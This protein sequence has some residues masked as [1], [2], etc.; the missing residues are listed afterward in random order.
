MK[1]FMLSSFGNI[2]VLKG[3]VALL[4]QRSISPRQRARGKADLRIKDKP[5]FF[6]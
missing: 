3:H 4:M 6:V 5:R 1:E 2:I